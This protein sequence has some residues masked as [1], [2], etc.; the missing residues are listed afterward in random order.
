MIDTTLLDVEWS[1]SGVN[2]T[3]VAVVEPVELMGSN[4]SRASLANPNILKELGLKIGSKV[5]ISKRGDIIP[6]VEYVISTPEEA[7]KIS[8]P[9]KCE[10]C[11]S[12][13]INEGTRLYCPNERC[14]NKAYHRLQK[15]IEK[16][17]VK[18]FSEKLML[19]NLF[20][21]GRVKKIS[22]LY[23]LTII[24]LTQF[25]GVQEKS[26][27]KAL[28]NLFAVKH[29]PLEVFIGGFDIEN[30]GERMVKKAVDEGFT[31][32]D[33]LR[34]ASTSDLVRVDGFAEITAKTLV[35][36][37]KDLYEDM[38]AVLNTGKISI[39]RPVS[40]GKLK[41]KT[42]CFTGKLN[43]MTRGEAQELVKKHGGEPKSSVVKDLTYLVTNST[44]QTAKYK[45]AQA[46]G[47]HIIDE[48]TFLDMISE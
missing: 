14:P 45:K 20:E 35:K 37:L 13:L 6:K 27:K 26:A 3:P 10:I 29:I 38:D 1:V 47:T 46:Q 40:G 25:E 28:D 15:W 8:I 43:T 39:S 17:G 36:G 33:S 44:T 2:Y 32:L 22:D 7:K 24:D 18:H 23:S 19:S 4:V 21:S 31:T 48:T 5:M 16:L 41:S 9:T 34:K 42:F 12:S 30:M 11:G